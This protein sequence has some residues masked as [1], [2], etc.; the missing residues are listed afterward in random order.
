MAEKAEI[1]IGATDATGPAFAT[2]QK[3]FQALAKTAGATAQQHQIA[4]VQ[5]KDFI[6]QIISGGSPIRAF[7]QQGAAV[8]SNYGGVSN[9]FKALTGLL[10]PMVI[11]IGAAAVGVGF[12]GAAFI[13]GAKQTKEF[14][15]A[16]TLTGNFAGQTAG[17]F[18]D[19]AKQIAATSQTTAS[20]ARDFG[21][22]LAKT[23]Q[24]GPQ[25]FRVATEAAVRYGEATG[26]TADAVAADFVSMGADV[27]KWAVEHNRQLHFITAAQY[28]QIKAL[29]DSG[30]EVQA[31]GVVYDALNQH[32][33]ALDSNLGYLDR[34][35]A[36]A[37]KGWEKFWNSAKSAGRA[38]TA[39][40]EIAR[41]ETRINASKAVAEGPKQA[42]EVT[43]VRVARGIAQDR[44]S[45]DQREQG[46]ALRRQFRESEN[47][48]MDAIS[49]WTEQERI[50]ADLRLE[51][52]DKQT[53]SAKEL[54]KALGQLQRDWA[55]K[56]AQG[57]PVLP[58]TQKLEEDAVRRQFAEAPDT[59]A[60]TKTLEGN[61]KE[62]QQGLE[63]EHD[64]VAFAQGRLD[65]LYQHGDLTIAQAFAAK[66][67]LADEDLQ[68]TLQ[69]YDA[70]IDALKKHQSALDKVPKGEAP[71]EK[72]ALKAAQLD[73]EN[74][75]NDLVAARAKA[76]R[77]AGQ[78]A[79]VAGTQETRAV[80]MLLKALTEFDAGLADLR[81]DK[82]TAEA[83]RN[84]QKLADTQKA[85]HLDP[86]QAQE[87][88]NL[89]DAQA[90]F[91]LAQETA[92][93]QAQQ[94]QTAE[95]LFAIQA[96]RDGVDRETAEKGLLALHEKD[97]AAQDKLIQQIGEQ[98]AQA[99]LL[100]N[101]I[102]DPRLI[103]FY[104]QLRIKREQAFD[105]KD[106]G[107]LRF[108]D[109]AKSSGDAIAQSFEDAA[110]QG[111]KLSDVISKLGLDLG[112]LVFHDLVTQPLSDSITQGIKGFG[113][114]VTAT[115]KLEGGTN[116][117]AGLNPAEFAPPAAAAQ[118][119]DTAGAAQA[120]GLFAPAV[121]AS[122]AALGGFTQA[123][124][125][126]SSAAGA[127]PGSIPTG[128]PLIGPP[129]PVLPPS[130]APVDTAATD[131]SDKAIA[132]L[133]DSAAQGAKGLE[134]STGQLVQ[135]VS[136]V[137]SSLGVLPGAFGQLLASL[138][139]L[140]SSSTAS[141]STGLLA[142]LAGLFTGGKTGGTGGTGGGFSTGG[143][144]QAAT[145]GPA[146]AGAFLQVNEKGPELLSINGRQFLMM[147]PQPG[148]IVP[149]DRVG[150]A[151]AGSDRVQVMP[152]HEPGSPG[153]ALDAIDGLRFQRFLATLLGGPDHPGVSAPLEPA[154]L[155]RNEVAAVLMGGPR[156]MREEVLTAD[157]PRHRD[158]L[159]RY[160]TGGL[161]G[162]GPDAAP[163]G[164][165]WRQ[166]EPGGNVYITNNT[167]A[168]V[169][170]TRDDKGDW[171]VMIEAAA[172]QA[173]QMVAADHA[174]GS[175]PS[176]A[177]LR[178]RGVNLDG[179]NP[180]RQ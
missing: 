171:R 54:D 68:A 155:G 116:L 87:Y 83:I 67:A 38:E 72:A 86:A 14:N 128:Q 165:P 6:E 174:S 154:P 164:A 114:A 169:S 53:H 51:A 133:T 89:L 9:T 41:L 166:R 28:E 65:E 70:Q 125:T 76:I 13:A 138:L 178:R 106:P 80:E 57:K 59:G 26:K 95:A 101:G 84:T 39:Q 17:Q 152:S 96:K 55:L 126:A 108:Y 73:D 175:G 10:S 88:K 179:S 137:T 42:V 40:Q 8:V 176:S 132:D 156:G 63:K 112:R 62:L 103:A 121:D 71:L 115:P 136:V 146:P 35:L 7:A 58:E 43:S 75:I 25:N 149:N 60:R 147:G 98:I 16:L 161:V 110:I 159:P 153:A 135:G 124:T 18:D 93:Q 15:D 36:A 81:G 140:V 157:D 131:A 97:I 123:L 77:E 24:V 139:A 45:A 113:Q 2:A 22:A 162:Q 143:S 150:P 142:S 180:R 46:L 29:Q 94:A 12:L 66:K 44:L 69:T 61:L 170:A 92:S 64:L 21:L 48:S 49:A 91:N 50:S 52:L 167:P 33:H 122:T 100:N 1:V 105:A 34:A 90:A 130:S 141:N 104:D 47:A 99:A 3:N 19:A 118:A 107:L 144:L 82:A 31:Q 120:A 4:A 119:A 158:N 27:A 5:V 172:K 127:A 32:L 117:F 168:T 145:G 148:R 23:G 56:A 111:G 134:V 74:K 20:A 109:L 160:H 151:L 11:G 78:A 85:L 129:A 37:S 163:I 177:A 79:Q 173:H 102:V 30:N